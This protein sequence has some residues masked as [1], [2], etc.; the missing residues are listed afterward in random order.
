MD[1]PA[2]LR[3]DGLDPKAKYTLRLTGYGA[4]LPLGDGQ[5]LTP[6]LYGKEIGE[7][8]EFPVPQSLTADGRL[9]VTFQTP[10]GEAGLNWRQQS[11]AS[12]VWLVKEESAGGK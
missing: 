4:A 5:A 7:L 1:W 9:E 6:T 10:P 3:Y 11:R 8:K 12:E 2:A